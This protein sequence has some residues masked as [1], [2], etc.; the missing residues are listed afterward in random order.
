MVHCM[1]HPAVASTSEES[2]TSLQILLRWDIG[3]NDGC[4]EDDEYGY[5]DD[6]DG[7]VCDGD[8]GEN[9]HAACEQGPT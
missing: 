5:A 3:G 4:C 2:E 1:R 8:G 7:G 6:D 9:D